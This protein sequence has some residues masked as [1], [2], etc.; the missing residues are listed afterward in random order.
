MYQNLPALPHSAP[1]HEE[2]ADSGTALP[3]MDA[4]C[5]GW[6]RSRVNGMVEQ[7]VEQFRKDKFRWSPASIEVHFERLLN[8][9]RPFLLL[10]HSRNN[11][12][13]RDDRTRR[14]ETIRHFR[15]YAVIATHPSHISSSNADHAA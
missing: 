3:A 10:T 9:R 7:R 8:P 4:L 6:N 13:D 12:R 1:S 14:D 15:E 5:I 2:E 11:F